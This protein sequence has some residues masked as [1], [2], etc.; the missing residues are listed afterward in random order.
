MKGEI[1]KIILLFVFF[2]LTSS[3]C[4]SA[5]YIKK[6]LP[7]DGE[8]NQNSP[9]EQN[10]PPEVRK[11]TIDSP[12]Q[13]IIPDQSPSIKEI[14]FLREEVSKLRTEASSQKDLLSTQKDLISSIK[15]TTDDLAKDQ[16]QLLTQF[17][18][19]SSSLQQILSATSFI[20]QFLAFKDTFIF[21]RD[22]KPY[23]Y[24]DNQTLNIYGY[25]NGNLLGWVNNLHEIIRNYDKSIIATLEGDFLID[26]S[27]HPIGTLERSETLR[28]ER[29]KIPSQ[30]QKTPV[31]HYLIRIENSRQFNQSIY[32]FTDWS[33]Q[34]LED[35]LF[36]PSDKVE[37]VR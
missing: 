16:N 14:Q 27:G 22:G 7:G 2:G 18:S 21:N 36:F 29:E 26:E 17:T 3:F 32:R 20:K 12:Q 24:I 28:L 23:A 1:K 5:T 6:E 37:K 19:A 35:L 11:Y 34:K 4:A 30:I 31:S 10:R 13:L 33:G 15:I 9:E 25:N 8:G